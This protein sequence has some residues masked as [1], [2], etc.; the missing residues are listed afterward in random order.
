MLRIIES[1][2]KFNSYV[3]ENTSCMFYYVEVLATKFTL[4]AHYL[5]LLEAIAEQ[6]GFY[7]ALI[8]FMSNV[9]ILLVIIQFT[10]E[11]TYKAARSLTNALT[12]KFL[13]LASSLKR[14][15]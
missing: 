12:A 4:A 13:K 6:Y 11:L 9:T 5:E 10:V 8:F 1:L 15:F 7:V 14:F 2:S 3:I